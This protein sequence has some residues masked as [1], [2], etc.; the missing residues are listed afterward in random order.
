MLRVSR[1][2][3][4]LFL[5]S[6]IYFIM[7]NYQVELINLLGIIRFSV[8]QRKQFHWLKVQKTSIYSIAIRFHGRQAIWRELIAS[9]T[10]HIEKIILP[11]DARVC[12]YF[13][14]KNANFMFSRNSLFVL[15]ALF[16]AIEWLKLR[17]NVSLQVVPLGG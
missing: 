15:K 16:Y 17:I 13:G 8:K 4:V 10:N 2:S 7:L 14:A 5:W 12:I 11:V 9:P 1:I 3:E 6:L